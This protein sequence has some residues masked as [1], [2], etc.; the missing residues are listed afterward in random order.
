MKKTNTFLALIL[1]AS[2]PLSGCATTYLGGEYRTKATDIVRKSD[3]QT[4]AKGSEWLFFWGLFDSGRFDLQKELKNQLREDEAVTDLEVK[5][6]LSVGGFF[7]WVITAGI[8]SHHTLVA[9]GHPAVVNR[10]PADRTGTTGAA[11]VRERETII[12]PATPV[13]AGSARDRSADYDAGLRDGQK[14]RGMDTKDRSI[15]SDRSQQYNDGYR[16]GLKDAAPR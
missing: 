6:R 10:P 13:P 8:I 9:K 1:A 14:E 11:P 12:I 15:K 7:L 2:M 16:D 3:K 5:D 4:L